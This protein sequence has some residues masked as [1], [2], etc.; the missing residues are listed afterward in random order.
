M[1]ERI[2]FYAG[3]PVRTMFGVNSRLYSWIHVK[4][5][6]AYVTKCSREIAR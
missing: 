2:W 4:W 3:Y 6:R 1:I 5:L